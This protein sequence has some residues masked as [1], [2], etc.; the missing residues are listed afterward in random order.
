MEEAGLPFAKLTR[1]G[2]VRAGSGGEEKGIFTGMRGHLLFSLLVL[3]S[4]CAAQCTANAGDSLHLCGNLG[5]GFDTLSLGGD[6]VVTGGVPP[7]T[8]AWTAYSDPGWGWTYDASDM[9]DDTS[10]AHPNLVSPIEEI[11]YT[12]I[13][14][15]SVGNTCVDSVFVGLS[16]FGI[17]LGFV[18]VNIVE[19]DSF[20]FFAGSNVDGD[21]PPFTYVWHPNE[22]LSDSTSLTAW[23][24]PTE[25]TDYSVTVT[26]AMGC[27]QEGSPL[28]LVNVSPLSI[29]D[30]THGGL[31]L[32]LAPQPASD[33]LTV[34]VDDGG[35]AGA[36][37]SICDV[38]GAEVLRAP[39]QG[40][41]TELDVSKLSGGLYALRLM[42]DG[43]LR[44]T[45]RFVVE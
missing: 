32:R 1:S 37:F 2:Q 21:H 44:A 19:G 10:L 4:R 8:Y 16:S 39:M 7:Y 43:D 25:G 31:V 30:A 24:S 5:G 3:G 18:T 29:K 33:V 17:T 14:T 34:T 13:V 38:A 11:W 9:L 6:P 35:Q 36:S 40:A 42:T 28:Y 27:S 45:S 41:R 23:A 22:S 12:L 15:D 26:D 20:Q